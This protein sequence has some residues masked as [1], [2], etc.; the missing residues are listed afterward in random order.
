MNADA[1]E[2]KTRN[3]HHLG[4]QAAFIDKHLRNV[5][6]NYDFDSF[7]IGIQPFSSD[8]RGFLFQD[9]QLGRRACSARATTTAGS[10]TSRTSAASRRTR[11]AA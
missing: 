1:R 2:G 8:F 6:D 4:I 7:R 3:D 10:T 11:T 5:S 9:N